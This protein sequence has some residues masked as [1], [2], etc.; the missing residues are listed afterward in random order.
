MGIRRTLSKLEN[1][2]PKPQINAE[3]LKK[4][5]LLFPPAVDAPLTEDEL[6]EAMKHCVTLNHDVVFSVAAVGAGINNKRSDSAPGISGLSARVVKQCWHRG[7]DHQRGHLTE[8][9]S[10]LGNAHVPWA[11]RNFLFLANLLKGVGLP[12]P[13]SD[14]IRPIGIAEILV[15]I[16]SSIVQRASRGALS[17]VCGGNLAIGVPGGTEVM[18]NAV[19]AALDADPRLVAIHL[20]IIN[21]FGTA[22]RR[23]LV[24]QLIKDIGEGHVA[25]VP[26]LRN[27][28]TLFYSGC[29]IVFNHSAG[30]G[31]T[32]IPFQTGFYQGGALCAP[33]CAIVVKNLKAR[34]RG[35][36]VSLIGSEARFVM[37]PSFADD[38][39][40]LVRQPFFEQVLNNFE[41]SIAEGTG[42]CSRAKMV[43]HRPCRSDA[44]HEALCV[45]LDN[46]NYK[47]NGSSYRN[48]A[49]ADQGVSAA[50]ASIGT[51]EYETAK[52][53][54]KR[55]RVLLLI[56]R[57]QA[58]L[59]AAPLSATRQPIERTRQALYTIALLVVQARFTYFTRVNKP[60]VTEPMG[61]EIDERLYSFVE[62]LLDVSAQELCLVK[63]SGP[64]A[65]A[66]RRK[67]LRILFELPTIK[68]GLGFH[69][70]S[71]DHT[72]AA[73]LASVVDTANRVRGLAWRFVCEPLP[74]GVDVPGASPVG[75]PFLPAV[76]AG[77]LESATQLRL[78]RP[79]MV[80]VLESS[81][82]AFSSAIEAEQIEQQDFKETQAVLAGGIYDSEQQFLIRHGMP[83]MYHRLIYRSNCDK[84][85][86]AWRCAI[87]AYFLGN[88]INDE[89]MVL[90]SRNFLFQRAAP[91]PT[92]WCAACATA[93][94]RRLV[95]FDDHHIITC[96][97]AAHGKEHDGTR[98]ALVRAIG[99]ALRNVGAG[100]MVGE[101][102][103][104][105]VTGLVSVPTVPAGARASVAVRDFDYS[106]ILPK[107]VVRADAVLTALPAPDALVPDVSLLDF[108]ATSPNKRYR[109]Q[110]SSEERLKA[111]SLDYSTG[112]AEKVKNLAFHTS[113]AINQG[114][115]VGFVA[116]PIERS[117]YLGRPARDFL[118]RAGHL[119]D[120]HEAT[121]TGRQR[122][123]RDLVEI[124]S[125]AWQAGLGAKMSRALQR[126][127]ANIPALRR[128]QLLP[129]N[130][131]QFIPPSPGDPP[132]PLGAP[133]G[134]PFS[135]EQSAGG[136][137]VAAP[138]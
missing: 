47:V 25:L 34:A 116:F 110:P 60:V 109:T 80:S 117:G 7:T 5:R 99:P 53:A 105:T 89:A 70:V 1:L 84:Y 111:I 16:A 4:I 134:A 43:V 48:L 55:D 2:Q 115:R 10:I 94:D 19:R 79:D 93:N 42:G 92:E 66:L 95:P 128:R 91:G 104:N 38:T 67:L 46:M 54:P 36:L 85:A 41:T 33:W 108:T 76:V 96:R 82:G 12:K 8:L 50:G 125:V 52:L 123:R 40:V 118:A 37:D 87:P 129:A 122:T 81:L 88:N 56:S 114:H 121:G 32:T 120:I 51:L 103:Y 11:W 69:S 72:H 136:A 30:D 62:R 15:N 21:A 63:T 98:D 9:L 14:A 59:D 71:G 112:L 28:L 68:G 77:A 64:Q 17:K 6:R 126:H 132:P 45:L 57:L 23:I 90:S 135:V 138:A 13:N 44:E 49:L 106:G 22:S 119:L 65:D 78:R 73:R 61:R 3:S 127:F 100:S 35:R 24:E 27:A 133:V 18:A 102:H 31:A 124:V 137:A 131:P 20:D 26:I 86:A 130:D 74:D 75:Q 101:T 97:S 113:F 39:F 83:S 58:V 29:S 107:R